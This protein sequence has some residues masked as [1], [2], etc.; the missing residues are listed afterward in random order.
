MESQNSSRNQAIVEFNIAQDALSQVRPQGL[1]EI[2]SFAN[3][4]GIVLKVLQLTYI[5]LG[6]KKPFSWDTMKQVIG[7][8]QYL[9]KLKA[10]NVDARLDPQIKE[11]LRVALQNP[12][13]N[14]ST[15]NNISLAAAHI[16]RY[17][18]HIYRAYDILAR[19]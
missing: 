18:S 3:P 1:A 11:K 12:E 19:G 9:G 16:F 14:E 15:I 7:N 8:A 2:R 13:L 17:I 5:L 10:F 4:P 6:N